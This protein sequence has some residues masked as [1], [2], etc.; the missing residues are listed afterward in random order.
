M[1]FE[2]FHCHTSGSK[3]RLWSLALPPSFSEFE[4][5]SCDPHKN[6]LRVFIGTAFPST[7][8]S[9]KEEA[10]P[11]TRPP[12]T[13]SPPRLRAGP[14]RPDRVLARRSAGGIRCPQGH[15]AGRGTGRHRFESNFP[16]VYKNKPPHF[17]VR[18]TPEPV[19]Q[20]LATHRTARASLRE[21]FLRAT[22][23]L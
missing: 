9:R 13:C 6:P 15:R 12:A 4:P 11:A 5:R 19:R 22:K 8:G 18:V 20:A 17:H 2:I 16:E 21:A 14:R 7:E 10:I 1:G 3:I 23:L